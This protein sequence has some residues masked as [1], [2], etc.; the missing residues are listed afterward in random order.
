MLYI[1]FV[2]LWILQVLLP[3]AAEVRRAV[4]VSLLRASSGAQ[5]QHVGHLGRAHVLRAQHPLHTSVLFMAEYRLKHFLFGHYHSVCFAGFG[6]TFYDSVTSP[7]VV[8]VQVPHGYTDPLRAPR[9]GSDVTIGATALARVRPT[10][11]EARPQLADLQRTQ[12]VY[13]QQRKQLTPVT[14]PSV[15]SSSMLSP[16]QPSVRENVPVLTQGPVS[17]LRPNEPFE[18]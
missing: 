16:I 5:L 14:S 2:L 4:L 7:A 11:P 8:E 1:S 9:P 15:Q 18:L 3:S 13:P 12:A 17:A 10:L 6:P